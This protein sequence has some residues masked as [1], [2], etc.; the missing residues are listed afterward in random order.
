MDKKTGFSG[1]GRVVLVAF[2]L[3]G[4]TSLGACKGGGEGD[5]QAKAPDAE[6]GPDPIPVEVARASHRAV[7][8]SYAGTGA[9]DPRAESQV[10]A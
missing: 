8:A 7:A 9:L 2:L 3:A 5:A 6:K 1:V 10:V 4:A